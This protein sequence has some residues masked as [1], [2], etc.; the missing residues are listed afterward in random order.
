NHSILKRWLAIGSIGL[1]LWI[2]SQ[3]IAT[4]GQA[5][6]PLATPP[7]SPISSPI[8]TTAPTLVPTT[9]P[10]SAPTVAPTP[11]QTAVPVPTTV[12]TTFAIPPAPT[13]GTS[14]DSST[15][16][17]IIGG[18]AIVLIL[19]LM[20]LGR[21]RRRPPVQPPTPLAPPAP[22]A[23]SLEFAG[24]D[25]KVLTFNLDKPVMVLGRAGSCDIVLPASLANVDSVS[26]QHAR[27]NRDQEGIMVHDL[28]SKNGLKVNGRYTNHNLLEDGDRLSF[29]S[30]EATFH[31]RR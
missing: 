21:S 24:A 19:I 31:N 29:G 16:L 6:S 20:I 10:T 2:A 4:S 25:G 30:V 17:L 8:P 7:T 18:A 1:A 5:G 9:A 14:I 12:P 13:A 15:L 11:T 26:H 3:P 27:F 28:E 22:T 23:A